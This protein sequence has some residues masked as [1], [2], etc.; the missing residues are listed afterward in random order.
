ME[1]SHK[2]NVCGTPVVTSHKYVQRLGSPFIRQLYCCMLPSSAVQLPFGPCV[3]CKDIMMC[4]PILCPHKAWTG[5][6]LRMAPVHVGFHVR[7]LTAPD[8]CRQYTRLKL[9]QPQAMKASRPG[10]GTCQRNRP[11]SPRQ[12]PRATGSYHPMIPTPPLS[13]SW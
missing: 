6:Q 12:H 13:H 5:M 9:G 10:S 8:F 7:G 4:G 1:A 11:H 3:E 2:S